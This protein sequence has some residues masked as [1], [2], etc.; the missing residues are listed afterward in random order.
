MFYNY[1]AALNTSFHC[2]SVKTKNICLCLNKN[3]PCN[4]TESLK[5]ISPIFACFR[6]VSVHDTYALLV[7]K[8]L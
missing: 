2:N 3:P 1:S 4:N 6:T 7:N 5:K 8:Q